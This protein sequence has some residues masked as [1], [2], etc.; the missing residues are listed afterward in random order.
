MYVAPEDRVADIPK[1]DWDAR[2][3]KREREEIAAAARRLPGGGNTT[4]TEQG[5]DALEALLPGVPVG[6][7]DLL[8]ASEWARVA[9]DPPKAARCLLTLRA[10]FPKADAAAII[11]RAP[12][13]AL[14][15]SPEEIAQDAAAARAVLDASA[16]GRD[17]PAAVDAAVELVPELATPKGVATAAS[18]LKKWHPKHDPFELMRKD[19]TVLVNQDESDLEADPIYGEVTSAG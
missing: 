13:L 14:L 4:N 6:S 12:R 16:L 10:A 18:Q 19:P 5:L 11:R 9:A 15:R 1:V 17:D 7:L 2:R 8:K 3:R